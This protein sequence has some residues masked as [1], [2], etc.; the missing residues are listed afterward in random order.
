V[1]RPC[2]RCLDLYFHDDVSPFSQLGSS[3][4][5]G[6]DREPALGPDVL[7]YVL[8]GKSRVYIDAYSFPYV[9]AERPGGEPFTLYIQANPF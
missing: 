8:G 4:E 1:V 2:R 5:A 3:I 7:T 9:M 6:V